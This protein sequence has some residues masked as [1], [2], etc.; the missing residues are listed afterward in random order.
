M[1]PTLHPAFEAAA[2]EA[3]VGDWI[4]E[5]AGFH[6]ELFRAAALAGEALPELG[7]DTPESVRIACAYRYA[8]AVGGMREAMERIPL[9][10]D[11]SP[12]AFA[13]KRR[14]VSVSPENEAAFQELLP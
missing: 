4:N 1:Q 10:A 9:R 3:A 6:A 5:V 7:Y 13:A 14:I 11:A 12:L 8:D 2:R